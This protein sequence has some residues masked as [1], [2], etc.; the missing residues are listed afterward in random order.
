M[1]FLFQGSLLVIVIMIDGRRVLNLLSK[2][3]HVCEK[4]SKEERIMALSSL[5]LGNL[6]SLCLQF[7]RGTASFFYFVRLLPRSSMAS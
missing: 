4:R 7:Y 5:D 1:C 6:G 3:S 2:S